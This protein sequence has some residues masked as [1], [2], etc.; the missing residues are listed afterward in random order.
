QIPTFFLSHARKDREMPGNYLR[1][2]FN[3]LESTL[4]QWTSAG[5]GTIDARV[6]QTANW[7]AELSNGLSNDKVFVAILTP[8]YFDRENCGQDLGVFLLRR[9]DLGIDSNG[10]LTGVKNVLLIRWLRE[11]AYTIN[12]NESVIPPILRLIEDSPAEDLNNTARTRAI[13]RYR[14][15]GMQN[16]VRPGTVYYQELLDAFVETIRDLPKIPSASAVSFSTAIDAFN[17]DWSKRFRTT[18]VAS[19][20][21]TSMNAGA[22]ATPNPFTSTVA[23]YVTN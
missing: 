5:R 15:M 20:A 18:S 9:P 11:N 6:P 21:P 14:Q 7:D 17:Y 8:F 2:F 3:D 19:A 23:F 13:K 10:S 22:Q 1:R 16:C 12:I 4:I